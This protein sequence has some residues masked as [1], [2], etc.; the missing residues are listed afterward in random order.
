MTD[1][2]D[3]FHSLGLATGHL[4]EATKE[5]ASITHDLDAITQSIGNRV[6]GKTYYHEVDSTLY[7]ATSKTFIGAMYAR[8]GMVNIA[9]AADSSGSGYPQLSAEF[10]VRQ[11]PDFVF[12]ADTVCC[13]ESATTFGA[14]PGFSSLKAVR[15]A[16]VELL[17]DPVAAQWGPRV[18]DFLRDIA[19]DVT[20]P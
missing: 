16:H 20:K 13:H 12:L 19:T 2:F 7:T 6:K 17:P 1:S 10:V 15:Q 4:S 18:V 11:D 9:D 5:Q 3:Q 8:L 14:R